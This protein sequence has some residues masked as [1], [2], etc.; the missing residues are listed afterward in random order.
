MTKLLYHTDAYLKE[1]ARRRRRGRWAAC[2][3]LD[4]SNGVL[5]DQRRPSP[6]IPARSAPA[7]SPGRCPRC[8]ARASWFGHTLQGRRPRPQSAIPCAARSIGS[9]ATS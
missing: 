4:I 8:A 2:V 5:R 7:A 9:G 1:F 6:M 3:A